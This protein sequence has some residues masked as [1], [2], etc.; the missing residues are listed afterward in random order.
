MNGD[1]V[2]SV[3]TELFVGRAADSAALHFDPEN[4]TLTIG[5]AVGHWANVVVLLWDVKE[6]RQTFEFESLSTFETSE[7][8]GYA[9]V[10]KRV[11]LRICRYRGELLGRER[12]AGDQ[13]CYG[14]STRLFNV[15]L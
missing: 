11:S 4:R 1:L 15:V 5:K 7:A 14:C 8:V 9:F 3:N 6:L 12:M 13:Q 10:S 2:D